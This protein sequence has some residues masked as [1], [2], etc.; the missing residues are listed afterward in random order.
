M[1]TMYPTLAAVLLAA[2]AIQPALAGDD[3][4]QRIAACTRERDDARRLACFDRAAAPAADAKKVDATQ[5]FGVHGS[6]LARNRDDDDPKQDNTPKRISATVAGVEK[7]ARGELLVTL[8]NGQVWA[9]KEVG[10]YFPLKVGDAV[11][12]IA[13]TFGSHKLVVASRATAV[14][15]VR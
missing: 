15:R 13:G 1:T 11:S 5:D 14:T 8:D 10:P 9:Q 3:L 7:R 2:A 4:S 6:E 12:I